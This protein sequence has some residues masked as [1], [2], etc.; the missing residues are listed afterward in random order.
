[1][2]IVFYLKINV[3]YVFFGDINFL[4]ALPGFL[5]LSDA[6]LPLNAFVL[7]CLCELYCAFNSEVSSEKCHSLTVP[8]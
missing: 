3:C 5:S 6:L 1:M 2:L 4:C 7:L 8:V